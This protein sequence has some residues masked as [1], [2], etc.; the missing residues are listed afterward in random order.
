MQ[1][2]KLQLALDTTDMP[3]A[4][5]PLGAAIG[6]IDI[7]E[8]GTVLII[9]EGLRCVREI[10]ALYPDKPILADV[11]IA[12]A[13][14]VIARLCFDAGASW[15]SVVAGASLTTV[16]QVVTVAREFGGEVQIELGETYD[17]A[18][19]AR[20]RDLG[21]QQVIVHRS[22][23]AEAAGT[24]SW[25]ADDCDHISELASLGFRVTVTGGIKPDALTALAGAPVGIVVAG[26][27]IVAAHD[28][29]A[30]ADQMRQA[31]DDVWPSR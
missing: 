15:V 27:Q 1:S 5:R 12:E 18:Q 26:R 14:S 13:G 11:R 25:G 16:G 6:S 2:P 22:R 19:A 10:R 7:I 31:I 3:S 4:L 29:K 9:A 23:D 28:P 24:L 20:W 30:A 17:A 8:C 21:A